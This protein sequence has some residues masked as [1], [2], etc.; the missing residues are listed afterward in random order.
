MALYPILTLPDPALRM[1]CAPVVVFDTTLKTLAVDM[2]NT[3]YAAPGRGLAAPQIG[4][5]QRLFVMD[6]DWK[7]G[8]KSAQVFVN[9]VITSQSDALST[10][11]EGCLSI[12]GVTQSV[13][14]PAEIELRWQD[15]N[16]AAHQAWFSDFSATCIQHERDHL[17]GVLCIDYKEIS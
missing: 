7:T 1:V 17:D 14:R 13:S 9:P 2:L 4:V 8:A 15:L 3:M 6:V 11:D 10:Y 12:P 16:G 5:S